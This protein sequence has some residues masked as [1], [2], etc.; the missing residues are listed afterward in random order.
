MRPHSNSRAHSLLAMILVPLIW[1]PYVAAD[2][3]AREAAFTNLLRE[4]RTVDQDWFQ[5]VHAAKDATTRV[6]IYQE[7]PPGKFAPRFLEFAEAKPTDAS[8]FEALKTVVRM[9]SG[10]GNSD[11]EYLPHYERALDNM[12]RHHRHRRLS[13]VIAQVGV[14]SD[15]SEEFLRILSEAKENPKLA[16]EATLALGRLL[17]R[18]RYLV[19]HRW[20]FSQTETDLRLRYLNDRQR[21]N[22]L[23]YLEGADEQK[24]LQ[25]SQRCFERVISEFGDMRDST[26]KTKL[27]DL[28]K[29]E[30]FEL[31]H[32]SVGNEAPRLTAD[33]LDGEPLD[34]QEFRGQVVLL[35]FWTSWCVPCMADVPYEKE[36]LERFQGRPFAIVGVNLDESHAE[37]LKAVEQHQIP[38]RSFWGGKLGVQGPIG[39]NW[40]VRSLPKVYVLDHKG[41]IRHKNIR[42][43]DLIEPV[44]RLVEAAEK[45]RDE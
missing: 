20:L 11:F 4:Y 22:Q 5:R 39:T 25:E 35:V 12:L 44:D 29:A 26:G 41:I 21:P 32:L 2:T 40:N 42:R 10:I 33:D 8:A 17:A 27:A 28:A 37:A 16:A 31:L 24:L 23:K 9:E 15:K 3:P 13:D 45:N 34:L 18:K 36:L 43:D 7:Y 38:W 1:S 30:L 6:A 19:Q 14:W